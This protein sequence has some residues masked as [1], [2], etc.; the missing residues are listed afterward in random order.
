[1]ILKYNRNLSK[2][3]KDDLGVII[4]AL[5]SVSLSLFLFLKGMDFVSSLRYV[6]Y[7]A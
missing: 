2:T 5:W 6:T 4:L 7:A 1:M 3:I